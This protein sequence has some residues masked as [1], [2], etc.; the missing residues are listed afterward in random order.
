MVVT[1]SGKVQTNEEAQVYVHDL[2][3][4]VTVRVLEETPSVFI[5]KNSAKTTATSGSAVKKTTVDQRGQDNLQA[6]RT[7]SYLLFFPGCPPVLVAVRLQHR[8]CKICLQ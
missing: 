6:K 8:H 4:F 3:L 7:L 5:W 1:A 2:D